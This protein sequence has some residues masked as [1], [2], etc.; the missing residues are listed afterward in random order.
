MPKPNHHIP[1]RIPYMALLICFCLA[2]LLHIQAE[3]GQAA[4]AMSGK[5]GNVPTDVSATSMRYDDASQTVV[6]E[7]GVHVK[8]PD[9]ELWADKITLYFLKK[10][11]AEKA[12]A[13]E[14]EDENESAAQRNSHGLGMQMQSGSIDRIIAENSVRIVKDDK[15]G[16]CN[17]GVYSVKTGILAMEGNPVI[18]DGKKNS[19]RGQ[20]I[21]FY[22][23]E[24]RSEVLGGVKATFSSQPGESGLVQSDNP[25]K[26]GK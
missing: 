23:N 14:A 9:F 15:V 1:C 11:K 3:T 12:A 22:I 16:T 8:R 6:F 25:R 5:G 18:Q 7:G 4:Q 13:P 26:N 24:N 2:G 17:K 21:K 20:I 10:G 19:I